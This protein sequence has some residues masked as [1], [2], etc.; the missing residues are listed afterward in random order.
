MK[1]L[2]NGE[3]V[4]DVGD[5]MDRALEIER[6]ILDHQEVIEVKAMSVNG[7]RKIIPAHLTYRLGDM[8]P[9]GK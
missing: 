4:L 5:T 9:K 3:A 8:W 6:E 7:G 1:L 2:M